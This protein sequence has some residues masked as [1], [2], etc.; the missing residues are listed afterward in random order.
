MRLLFLILMMAGVAGCQTPDFLIRDPAVRV[1]RYLEENLDR[2][3]A[4]RDA[5]AAGTPC[6]GMTHEEVILCWGKPDKVETSAEGINKEEVW[7]Y[8]TKPV[9]EHK[10]SWDIV[11]ELAE[12][13]F[14]GQGEAMVMVS[15]EEFAKTAAK[16]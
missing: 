14:Q 12:V 9:T 1:A 7:T 8:T 5:L 6:V 4:I 3:D 2:P 10:M 13:V 15:S 11:V 16:P